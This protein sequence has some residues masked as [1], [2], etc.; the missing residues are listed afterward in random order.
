MTGTAVADRITVGEHMAAIPTTAQA[1]L[2]GDVGY[3]HLSLI[4]HTHEAICQPEVPKLLLEEQLLGR[5]MDMSVGAF[6]FFCQH[7]RHAA[8]PAGPQA[9]QVEAVEQRKLR[10]HNWDRSVVSISGQLDAAGAAALKTALLPLA[11]K[12]GRRDYRHR[13]RRMMD[14][15][16]ELA[17][18]RLSRPSLQVTTSIETLIG[19]AGAPAGEMEL[20]LP[21][22]ASTVQRLACDCGLTRVLLDS[23][24]MVIDVGRAKRVIS[25]PLRKALHVRD[26]HCQWPGCERPATFSEGHHVIH[27]SKGGKTDLANLVL[28]C[29]RHH[30]LVHEGGWQLVKAEDGRLLTVKPLHRLFERRARGPDARA[31]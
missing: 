31:A 2:S 12:Q 20:S 24:S 19:L 8:D 18:S 17:D 6:R 25:G 1:V 5:A 10:F 3:A 21:I 15:L 27:W 11:R 4:S 30:W 14:A 26:K 16:L 29:Y 13:D 28:L 9:E 23:E 7:A 22:C